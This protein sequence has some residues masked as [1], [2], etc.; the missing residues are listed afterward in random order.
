MLD[1]LLH[2]SLRNKLAPL[3]LAAIIAGWGYYAYS[4]LTVEAFPDPTDTQVTSH[5]ALPGAADRGGRAARL[6][7]ARARA[8][9]HAGSVP[10]AQHL[11]VR[12][13]VR[14]ADLRRRRRSA[15]RARSRSL[16]R[17]AEAELPE[18]VQPGARAAGH[19]DRRG[20]SL[21]ARRP[22]HRSDDAARRCRIGWCGR[23]CCRSPASPTS[24]P[25]AACQGDPRRAATRP[26]W[27]R[28]ASSSTDVFTALK[29]ASANATGGYVERGAEMFVIRSLGIFTRLRRHRAGARRAPTTASR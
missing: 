23:G 9:R 4:R 21:H 3:V 15:D 5:H 28:S 27:P 2:Q 7:P 14:H 16:E 12:P 8:Q 18:G 19:A 26:R 24:S 11:A 20:L 6:A 25:T 13:V 22:G 1:A 10:A 17:L 29:K